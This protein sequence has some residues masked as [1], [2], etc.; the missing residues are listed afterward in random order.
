[1]S[2]R[3][4]AM[5]APVR[6]LMLT[7]HVTSS[8]GWLGAVA[9]FLALAVAGMTS[10]DATVEHGAYLAMGMIAWQVIIPLA[11]TSLVT[12]V[13]SSL[14]TTWGLF[15]Y[16]WIVFK[17]LLTSFSTAILMMHMAPIDALA[18]AAAHAVNL[19]TAPQGP[20]RLMVLASTLAIVTLVV[21]T[22]LSVYK[23][24]GITPWSARRQTRTT[25]P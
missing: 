2:V 25:P 20:Q 10:R 24:R 22:A 13:A 18:G 5:S 19:S 12:G 7:A 3:P 4:I 14:G 23:P 9:A 8:V 17:L 16:Y 6:K 21:V 1:M 15:R 11:F